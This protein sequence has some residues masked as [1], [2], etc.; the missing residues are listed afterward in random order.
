MIFRKQQNTSKRK[1]YDSV[2]IIFFA[3]LFFFSLNSL[4]GL[5][6]QGDYSYQISSI[7]SIT[8]TY[9]EVRYRRNADFRWRTADYGQQLKIRDRIFTGSDSQAD[10]DVQKNK[11][12][13]KENSLVEIGPPKEY[14]LK[15]EFGY[16]ALNMNK[17]PMRILVKGKKYLIRP[18]EAMDLSIKL[19]G[20]DLEFIGDQEKVSIVETTDTEPVEVLEEDFFNREI[21]DTDTT[22]PKI[23]LSRLCPNCNETN[24]LVLVTESGTEKSLKGVGFLELDRG[25]NIFRIDNRKESCVI[26]LLPIAIPQLKIGDSKTQLDFETGEAEMRI[27]VSDDDSSLEAKYFKLEIS[28]DENFDNPRTIKFHSNSYQITLDKEGRYFF[29]ISVCGK[30]ECSDSSAPVVLDLSKPDKLPP[31]RLDEI[32]RIKKRNGLT[33]RYPNNLDSVLFS[34]VAGAKSY[35]FKI[36]F[37]DKIYLSGEVLEP[38][39]DVTKLSPGS[40]RLVVSPVD[41][42][43]RE[44]QF[45][46]TS[47]EIEEVQNENI[48]QGLL[49][50][51]VFKLSRHFLKYATGLN[52]FQMSQTGDI[53][54]AKGGAYLP[55]WLNFEVGREIEDNEIGFIYQQYN[56]ETESSSDQ[57][58]VNI[59]LQDYQAYF[60][61]KNIRVGAGRSQIPYINVQ[62]GELNISRDQINFL[63]LGFQKKGDQT[64]LELRYRRGLNA[65]SSVKEHNAGIFIFEF[66]K[67]ITKTRL[68]WYNGI[69]VVAQF[70]K[71]DV[72]GETA[73]QILIREFIK[74]G[75]R[76]EF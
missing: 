56:I 34:P 63:D 52:L 30:K 57:S 29:R 10:I 75:L 43:G 19:D 12:R 65:K 33:D 5:K 69:E 73:E 23:A 11:I 3:I 39:I 49:E 25:K 14:D 71:L 22:N 42:W 24:H 38:E 55:S 66:Q 8:R 59:S 54:N 1:S 32:Y 31:P 35:R 7:A 68:Y 21:C 47:I 74:M 70:N 36:L 67:A 62:N 16:L 13:I 17:S 26:S 58:V 41:R 60:I 28:N 53:G 76:L 61:R 44:G 18:K 72:Q 48:V 4:I 2:L 15:F 37:E 64:C 20:K 40:Y 46:S 50:A 51:E 6:R 9:R 45:A 27:L